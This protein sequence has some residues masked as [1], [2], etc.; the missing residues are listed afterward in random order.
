MSD[1]RRVLVIGPLPPPWGGA[2]VAF[3]SFWDYLAALPDDGG[4]TV[5]LVDAT[6][7]RRSQEPLVS[8]AAVARNGSLFAGLAVRA[9][10]CDHV[11]FF[12]SQRFVAW[13]A[14]PLLRLLRPLGVTASVRLFGGGFARYLDELPRPA[15]RA[16]AR[17]LDGCEAVVVQSHALREDLVP[18]LR[19]PI[20]TVPNYRVLGPVPART[21]S[22]T[23]HFVYAGFLR[24]AKGTLDL[25]AAFARVR[26]RATQAVTLDLYGPL[27]ADEVPAGTLEAADGVVWHGEV[28]HDTARAAVA[29][30]DVVVYP[31]AWSRE[32]MPG[33][34]LEALGAGVAV[35]ATRWAE[36]PRL[37]VDGES[38]LLVEPGDV[39]GLAA[40][41]ARLAD[42]GDL[43]R[44]LGG[45]G[46][47]AAAPYDAA[48]VCPKLARVLGITAPGAARA[49]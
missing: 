18:W 29:G 3:R 1:R 36:I 24:R 42:D 16:V 33:T 46:P 45:A 17:M 4:P 28:P 34:V 41:M 8:P 13:F 5:D 23:V 25:L 22:S 27:F 32:G 44:R 7:R 12:G 21:P 35:V 37:V 10:R 38:G 19:A 11:V 48:V 40:A 15:A 14:A 30:A 2:A 6:W 20:M 31:T 26:R 39:D 47:V 49:G 9:A 43:R